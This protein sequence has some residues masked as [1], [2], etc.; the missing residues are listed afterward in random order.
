MMMWK[1][2]FFIKI[3][4]FFNAQTNILKSIDDTLKEINNNLQTNNYQHINKK[5]SLTRD[6]TE[7]IQGTGFIPMIDTGG[8]S[9]TSDKSTKRKTITRDFTEISKK[10]KETE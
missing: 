4:N 7:R 6:E 2:K 3:K 8:L 5:T 10:I 1:I 9:V